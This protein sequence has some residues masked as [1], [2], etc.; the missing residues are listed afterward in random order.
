MKI[1]IKL[2]NIVFLTSF[3]NFWVFITLQWRR[4][5]LEKKVVFLEWKSLIYLGYL[6][7]YFYGQNVCLKYF[8]YFNFKYLNIWHITILKQQISH[9]HILFRIYF[10]NLI[11]IVVLI[12]EKRFLSPLYFSFICSLV[13]RLNIYWRE[14]KVFHKYDMELFFLLY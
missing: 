13:R 12:I 1:L 3:I 8:K 2:K 9:Q 11:F 5:H 14:T 7:P 6:T 10:Q 4:K